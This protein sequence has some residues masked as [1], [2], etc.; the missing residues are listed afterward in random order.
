MF[1]RQN[2]IF[3]C[4]LFITSLNFPVFSQV[5]D[6]VDED[7]EEMNNLMEEYFRKGELD[8][9][10]ALYVDDAYLITPDRTV[11]GSEEIT[12]YWTAIKDPVEW[13]LEVIEVSQNEREI[14]R[15]EYYEALDRKPPGWRQRG[16]ELDEDKPLVYQLGRSK[17]ISRNQEGE[18][19][20]SEVDFILIWEVTSDG[21][22]RILLDTYTW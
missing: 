2:I 9:I 6:T 20:T 7:I 15:N 3:C 14:Y 8:K 22:Y 18:L 13:E 16:I 4:T 5:F 21:S 17:L 19:Q 12:K 10:A 1:V 11:T